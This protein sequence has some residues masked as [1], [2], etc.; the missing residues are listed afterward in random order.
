MNRLLQGDVGAGKTLVALFA[1][2]AC[3]EAGKQ[4]ALMAPT[5][6]LAKQHLESLLPLTQSAGIK[7]EL[8]TGRDKGAA[9]RQKLERLEQGDVQILLGTHAV[10]QADVQF[11]NLALAVIDEQHRFG[12]RQRLELGNKGE[13]VDV[14]VMTATP[15]PRSL[16]LAHY[17][18]MDVSILDEK[19][20]GRKPIQTVL[21]GAERLDEIVARLSS[22]I[23]DG[24][25]CYWFA[26]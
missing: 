1:M 25:Q 5:E 10:F 11:H 26:H 22:A 9:R 20:P 12:V 4:A 17:G 6:I 2:I 7:I 15:I 18:D 23:E 14:L 16:A 21:I 24:R 8:L 19:P 13:H 3:V